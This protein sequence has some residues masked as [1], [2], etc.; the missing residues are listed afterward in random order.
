MPEKPKKRKPVHCVQLKPGEAER[1][2]AILDEGRSTRTILV[3]CLILLLSNEKDGTCP[4]RKEIA[5][6]L[7]IAEITVSN[8]TKQYKYYGLERVLTIGGPKNDIW[9]WDKD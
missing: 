1:L 7:G 9:D 3:R 6:R 2:Q 5:E 8:V 4:S